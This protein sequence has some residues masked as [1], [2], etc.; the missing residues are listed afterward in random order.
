[1]ILPG[2]VSV[3]FRD[4]TVGEVAQ[5]GSRAGLSGV[6]WGADVH[7]PPGDRDAV[8]EA[9][10]ASAG[11]GL[12]ITGYG[13]YFWAG[14]DDDDD[15]TRVLDTALELGAPSIRVWAGRRASVDGDAAYRDAV[16][17]GVRHA[18]ERARAHGV[19]V[20]LEFH[21]GTLTDTPEGAVA[22]CAA[23][24]ARSHWQPPV[25][26]SD[27]DALA[28]L[29]L[30]ASDLASVHVF[31]WGP[32]GERHRL[33]ERRALWASALQRV[34]ALPGDHPALLEFVADD[35]PANLATD[36]A[37][38]LDLVAEAGAHAAR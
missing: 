38:L 4:R 34:V 5:L 8:R 32:A 30:V 33:A 10:T 17:G 7:V 12:T 28:G 24:G 35:D 20:A 29:E 37:T 31:S 15:F 18:V 6:D 22:L 19:E 11:E 2:V 25:G 9:V 1:M 23:T 36:A 14:E 13:S 16:V 3:T 27:D 21:G 26:L